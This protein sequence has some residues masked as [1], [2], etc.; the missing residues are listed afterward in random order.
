M[1]ESVKEEKKEDAAG[2][3]YA[4]SLN[5]DRDQT[6]RASRVTGSRSIEV[7]LAEI[8]IIKHNVYVQRKERSLPEVLAVYGNTR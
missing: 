8:Q 1:D 5:G 6:F 7:A 3:L 2:D 4:L